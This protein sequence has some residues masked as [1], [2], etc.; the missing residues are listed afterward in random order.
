MIGLQ[1]NLKALTGQRGDWLKDGKPVKAGI[2]A[3]A[4]AEKLAAQMEVDFSRRKGYTHGYTQV[5]MSMNNLQ[6]TDSRSVIDCD[7]AAN[8]G[9]MGASREDH[10]D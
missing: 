2:D 3:I 6:L 5:M 10:I 9:D 8:E 4:D 1:T 7:E